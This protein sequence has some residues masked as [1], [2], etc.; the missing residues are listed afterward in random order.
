MQGGRDLFRSEDECAYRS[1]VKPG[2]LGTVGSHMQT[3][4]TL[5][6]NHWQKPSQ[7]WRL[8]KD[9][10]VPPC[11]R[12]LHVRSGAPVQNM[13]FYFHLA[14]LQAWRRLLCLCSCRQGEYEQD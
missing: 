13:R 7:G 9:V 3:R 6:F 8:A 11:K 4:L 5:H 12:Q 14:E 1:L 10:A 2:E